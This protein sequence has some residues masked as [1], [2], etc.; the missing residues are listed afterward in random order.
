MDPATEKVP[1]RTLRRDSPADRAAE[2]LRGWIEAGARIVALLA[3][4]GAERRHV[5]GLLAESL[6]GRFVIRPWSGHGWSLA[7]S[8]VAIAS[9][10]RRAAVPTLLL[11]EEGERISAEEARV[12][13]ALTADPAGA[14]C[15]AIALEASG[16]GDVLGGLG[17]SL[18]VVVLRGTP[19]R[20]ARATRLRGLMA[21]GALL[22][23]GI[24]LGLAAS[25]LLP[26]FA[27]SPRAPAVETEAIAPAPA[28]P[29]PPVAAAPR[30]LAPPPPSPA[31]AEHRPA[32]P[33]TVPAPRQ[34]PKPRP[35]PAEPAPREAAAVASVP[36]PGWLVVNSIPRATIALDGAPLGPTPIVR[37]PVAG[38]HHRVSAR[39]G[40]GRQEE[41]T[42]QVS[43]AEVYLMFDGR[44]ATRGEPAP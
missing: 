43:G 25:L 31:A 9:D 36:G 39:F 26:R 6:E 42:V 14:R 12:L 24:S 10:V 3:P 44:T 2:E 37:H 5:L 15:A 19:A 34:A 38:G 16:S 23:A 7:A 33:R 41:R 17:P 29:L 28:P 11:V 1:T 22:A 30:D 21:A 27:S 40:D 32:A 8:R 18:E 20:P 35:S 13:K 4:P